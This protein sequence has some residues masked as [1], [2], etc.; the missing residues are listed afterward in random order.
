[1][2]PRFVARYMKDCYVLTVCCN[3]PKIVVSL[4]CRHSLWRPTWNPGM[5]PQIV[6]TYKKVWYVAA[7]CSDLHGSLVCCHSFW[8]HIWK[9]GFSPYFVVTYQKNPGMSPQIVATYK[10]VLYVATVCGDLHEILVGRNRLWRLT[11]T[12]GMS[13]SVINWGSL[14]KKG[15]WK[16]KNHLEDLI[17]YL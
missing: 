16:Q 17:S 4:L 11:W 12:S 5:S 2:L 6:A 14:L 15:V 8:Q 10:E 7:D 1:M 9:T 13:L 3:L